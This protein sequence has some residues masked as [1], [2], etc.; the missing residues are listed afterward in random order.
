MTFNE[1]C[2]ELKK[3]RSGQYG[4]E[5]EAMRIIRAKYEGLYRQLQ[6]ERIKTKNHLNIEVGDIISCEDT[7]LQVR[8]VFLSNA[9]SEG[10]EF[11]EFR[12]VSLTKQLKPKKTQERAFI[13][14]R[15]GRT[16]TIIKKVENKP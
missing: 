7:I 3:L 5:Q 13:Q 9:S 4:E 8:D 15:Y 10:E 12:G 11:I 1:Y 16:I 2:E 6:M 14:D